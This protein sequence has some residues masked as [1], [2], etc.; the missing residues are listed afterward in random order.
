MVVAKI[1]DV[2]DVKADSLRAIQIMKTLAEY[3]SKKAE[4]TINRFVMDSASNAREISLI[5]Q[6]LPREYETETVIDSTAGLFLQNNV[7]S[8]ASPPVLPPPVKPPS[9][10]K[11]EKQETKNKQNNK[12][13][14]PSPKKKNP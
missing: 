11:P 4:D 5:I 13:I 1:K 8:N 10:V 7:K 14:A 9:N 6:S 3:A 2:A 12:L